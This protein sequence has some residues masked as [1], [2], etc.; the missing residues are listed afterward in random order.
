MRA[1]LP[2]ETAW[3]GPWFYVNGLR[4]ELS[5]EWCIC[6][7][8]RETAQHVAAT[9]RRSDKIQV[10]VVDLGPLPETA[11]L[12]KFGACQANQDAAAD[13]LSSRKRQRLR[14]ALVSKTAKV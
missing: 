6:W 12:A 8:D 5:D 1:L 10:E 3:G 11:E 9:M 14:F 13:A 2:G 4:G 7:P